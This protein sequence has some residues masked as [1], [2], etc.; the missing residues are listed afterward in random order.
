MRVRLELRA[1][2]RPSISRRDFSQSGGERERDGRLFSSP[3]PSHNAQQ[4]DF[5]RTVFFGNMDLEYEVLQ[6]V[7]NFSWGAVGSNKYPN[8]P[9]LVLSL[10]KSC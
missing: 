5:F 6:G 1:D 8:L 3:P 2:Q 7:V 4:D 10:T 9:N